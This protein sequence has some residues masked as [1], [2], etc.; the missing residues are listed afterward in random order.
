MNSDRSYGILCTATT[1]RAVPRTQSTLDLPTQ[2]RAYFA[3]PTPTLTAWNGHSCPSPLTRF[4][5]VLVRVERPPV[6]LTK[7]GT[8]S[9]VPQRTV[10]KK[11]S[12]EKEQF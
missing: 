9:A 5:S 8:A 3:R 12:F 6:F 2:H 4:D 7:K 11:N 1:D 10:L